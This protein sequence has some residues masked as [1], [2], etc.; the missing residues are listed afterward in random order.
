MLEE[1]PNTRGY[2]TPAPYTLTETSATDKTAWTRVEVRRPSIF[3]PTLQQGPHNIQYTFAGPDDSTYDLGAFYNSESGMCIMRGIGSWW[4]RAPQVGGAPASVKCVLLDGMS[5]DSMITLTT[6][7]DPAAWMAKFEPRN[8]GSPLQNAD[9]DQVSEQ[10]FVGVAG[11]RF[12]Y[13]RNTSAAGQTIWLGIGVAAE[14]GKGI[15]LSPDEAIAFDAL[16]GVTEQTFNVIADADN[17]TVAY[18]LGL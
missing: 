3:R 4:V 9:V 14:V 12:I 11:R 15:G 10:L 13:I 5:S 6:I 16:D 2:A 17:A 8:M 18:Q 7:E 1:F